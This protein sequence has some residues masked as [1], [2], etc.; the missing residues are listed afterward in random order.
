[1]DS[2]AFV[3]GVAVVLLALHAVVVAYLYRAALPGDREAGDTEASTDGRAT[4]PTDRWLQSSEGTEE[5]T[6]STGDDDALQCP[7]CGSDNDPGY[8]F[9]RNCVADLS[10]SNRTP[11]SDG[12]GR[13]GS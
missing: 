12:A 2:L 5:T 1:M 9:C 4:Y 3:V 11:V 6:S 8:Q 10:G 13:L 7:T